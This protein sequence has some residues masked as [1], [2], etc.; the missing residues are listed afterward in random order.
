MFWVVLFT[1]TGN[2]GGGQSHCEDKRNHI[3][4]VKGGLDVI[5]YSPANALTASC[6][7][8]F[9]AYPVTANVRAPGNTA[10]DSHVNRRTKAVIVRYAEPESCP[11]FLYVC[12]V[13]IS[14]MTRFGAQP[15]VGS[16]IHH[17]VSY[18]F[19]SCIVRT[20]L[21]NGLVDRDCRVAL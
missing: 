21:C 14:V 2:N 7:V 10:L 5:P 15:V 18:T 19:M 8:L 9:Y 12:A 17:C 20:P 11:S 16:G 4:G 3:G 1:V 13:L 6:V